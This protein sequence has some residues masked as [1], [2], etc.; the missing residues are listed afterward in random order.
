MIVKTMK[1]DI[2]TLSKTFAKE[3][4]PITT[5]KKLINAI[6]EENFKNIN[7][8]NIK[9]RYSSSKDKVALHI[10]KAIYQ[11]VY[12]CECYDKLMGLLIEIYAIVDIL[13]ET[14]RHI[15]DIAR[16]PISI[17]YDHMDSYGFTL[18]KLFDD[19]INY[20]IAK[21]IYYFLRRKGTP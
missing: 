1:L 14:R 18:Y 16:Q 10:E 15:T 8:T 9:S 5:F 17:V 20:E 11:S 13:V 6:I 19:K 2:N 7:E 4:V 12:R 21:N 3:N